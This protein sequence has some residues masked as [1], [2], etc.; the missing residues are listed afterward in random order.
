MDGKRTVLFVHNYYQFP[1]GEDSVVANEKEILEEQGYCVLLYSRNNNEIKSFSFLRKMLLSLTTVFNFKTYYDVRRIIKE[2]GVDIIHVH[3]TLNLISPA[4]YYAAKSMNRPVVQT[5]HN[6]RLLCPGATFYREGHICEDCIKKGLWCAVKYNCYRQSK[7]QTLAC[8]VTTWI[9]RK[10]GIYGYLH[11]ICLTEFNKQKLLE[12]KQIR[13]ANVYIK[14]NFTRSIID[15]VIPYE[16][17]KDQFVFAG[18]LDRLK[19]IDFLLEAWKKMGSQ[20][21]KLV[22]CGTGPMQQWCEQYVVNHHL[23]SVD[24]RGFIPNE[25][26][27]RI[28]AESKAMVLPTQW[29]EGF[30]MS[31]VEAYSV[32]T[33]VLGSAIGNTKN[34]IVEGKTGWSFHIGDDV[35]FCEKV[36][37]SEWNMNQDVKRHF[38]EHYSKTK[39]AGMLID[40]YGEVLK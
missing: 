10:I 9:H 40:I 29:Y 5:V 16:K 35:D 21:P 19:G 22:I 12:L 26:A 31:I 38:E 24:L 3:N 37:T 20:A 23:N 2:N 8:V 39:N 13:Q 18:R 14:P 25:Q 7:L 36:Q 33:P 28:I 6:F 32:G 17:R 30:P 27:K 4:V 15:E 1:G 11:Y 34:L